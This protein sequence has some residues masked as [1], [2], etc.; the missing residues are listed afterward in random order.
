MS[1]IVLRN[2]IISAV[3][4]V[5]LVIVIMVRNRSPYGKRQ[6]YFAAVPK[7]EI[8]GIELTKGEKNLNLLKTDEGW[9]VNGTMETRKNE[10][11]FL[12]RILTEME[13]KSP[14]SPDLFEKEIVEN[15]IL[16]VKV[17]VY[18][19]NR[20]LS[21]FLVYR[22]GSNI[23]GN[24]MKKKVRTKPFIV[25]VPGYEGDIGSQFTANEYYWQPWNIFNL[26]PSEI[27][28]VTLKNYSEP[29]SSFT[30]TGSNGIY[31]LADPRE[32]SSGWDTARVKRYISYFTWVPFESWA[33]DITDDR[34]EEITKHNPLFRI[35]VRTTNGREIVLTLWERY[36]TD[37]GEKDSDRLWGMTD[38]RDEFFVVRYFDIDPLL[39]KISYFCKE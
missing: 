15:G 10:I 32:C 29:A 25:Y 35:M 1:N 17:R 37:T 19:R 33:S 2:T 24:I 5:L 13:I 38:E 23:Y 31:T 12:I 3:L 28:S 36:D 34:K 14:V 22:T 26:L 6:S 8:T 7:E 16:P 4:I 11:L 27:S 9:K 21:S 18:E 20:L 39:K 30:V